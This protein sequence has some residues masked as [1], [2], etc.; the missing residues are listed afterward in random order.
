VELI[1]PVGRAWW[2]GPGPND[3]QYAKG[4]RHPDILQL[5]HTILRLWTFFQYKWWRYRGVVRQ[6][7]AAHRFGRFFRG[8]IRFY[9]KCRSTGRHGLI[10]WLPTSI[11]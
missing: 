11:R 10:I 6:L 3:A 8:K 2:N 4:T 5:G 1:K 7:R 9:L